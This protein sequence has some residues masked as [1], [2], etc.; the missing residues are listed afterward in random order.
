MKKLLFVLVILALTAIVCNA[1]E[2]NVIIDT[3]NPLGPLKPIMHEFAQG[4]ES[5]NPNNLLPIVDKMRELHPNIIRIDHLYDYYCKCEIKDGHINVDFSNLDRY[6]DSIIA[7]GARPLMSLSYTP[8]PLSDEKYSVPNDRKLW[9]ELV[10]KTVRHFNVERKLG[11]EYWEFWNEPECG[12]FSGTIQDYLSFY[13]LTSKVATRADSRIKF[14]GP[15]SSSFKE[16]WIKSLIDYAKEGNLRLD[17]ISWHDYHDTSCHFIDD[18]ARVREW[19]SQKGMNA[20]LII[21]E[22][23]FDAGLVP[24]NDDY[25][26]AVYIARTICEAMDSEIDHM[27]FFEL[28]DSPKENSRY[29]GRWGLFTADNQ[30]KTPYYAF[31]MFSK[32][33]GKRFKLDCSSTNIGGIAAGK[34][35]KCNV[36]LYNTSN[37]ESSNI[38]LKIVGL[39]TTR[40]NI[41]CFLIDKTHTNSQEL[42]SNCRL[43]EVENQTIAGSPGILPVTVNLPNTSVMLIQIN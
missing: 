30:A 33:S 3:S 10:Y 41:K 19:L 6:I 27:P 40:A 20:E 23:N 24:E 13:S 15:T 8:K 5:T 9:A 11:I 36:I 43:E 21:D 37:T 22:W 18:S 25:R 28:K 34:D 12:F 32:L 4:G 14:G 42:G 35:G 17:F 39:N 2:V 29:W 38:N 26:G 1:A 16:Y 7:M 31:L